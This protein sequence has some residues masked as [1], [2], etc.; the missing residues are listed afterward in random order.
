MDN[1]TK[2]Y[3]LKKSDA[4]MI[5]KA[6]KQTAAQFRPITL[7]DVY[8]KLYITIQGKKIDKHI[9]DNNKQMETQAFHQRQPNKRQLNHPAILY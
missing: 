1:D 3:A 5:P 9:L 4:Q 6:K 2:G 7:T 8:Y